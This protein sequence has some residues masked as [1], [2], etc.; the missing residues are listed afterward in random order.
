MKFQKALITGGAG[1]IGSHIVE[2]LLKEG[3]EPV[4]FDDFSM[5]RKENIHPDV[6]IIEGDILDERQL[7]LALN[8][9]DAVFHEAARVSIRGSVTKFYTDAQTNIMG[10]LNLL[11]QLAKSKV[12]KLIYAS[13][14]AVYGETKSLPISE[15]YPLNPI[16][17]YGISK[18]AGEKY[19]LELGKVAGIDVVALR[20]FNTYGI[21]QTLTPYVGVITIFI[22]RLLKGKPPVIFGDGEQIRDFISVKDIARAN[23]LAMEGNYNGEIFNVGTGNGTTINQLADFIITHFRVKVVKEYGPKQLGE[24]GN[25]IA[26]ISKIKKLM[27]FK[28]KFSL[29]DDVPSIVKWIKSN[30]AEYAKYI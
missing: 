19:C 8:G 11:K 24:P 6:K 4:V 18:L 10:T 7:G 9:I 29:R 17:P 12:K 20:Y 30:S 16:S 2:A 5:G 15:N 13:S 3:I 26:D 27:R 22:H 23:I 21:R 14:M 25:S 28:P 1:F